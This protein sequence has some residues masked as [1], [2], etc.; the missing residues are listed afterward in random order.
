MTDEQLEGKLRFHHTEVEKLEAEAE[1]RKRTPS[2]EE[3]D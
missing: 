3:D 1:A 2:K